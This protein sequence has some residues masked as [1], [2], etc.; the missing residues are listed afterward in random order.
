MEA[1]AY[2]LLNRLHKTIKRNGP[3]RKLYTAT[4]VDRPHSVESSYLGFHNR[5][6]WTPADWTF[7]IAEAGADMEDVVQLLKVTNDE[8]KTARD[9]MQKM[10]NQIVAMH[11]KTVGPLM[12]HIDDIRRKRQTLD[13]ETHQMLKALG[14]VREFFIESKYEIEIT[15]LKDFI[16]CL[17]KLQR[18]K[19]DGTLDAFADTIIH[20]A[21]KEKSNGGQQ[22]DEKGPQNQ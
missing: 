17:E 14:E 22:G 16:V 2:H 5:N 13:N 3:L 15:R 8:L 1:D 21:V 4:Y 9:E 7:P 10:C 6:G 20:L 18:F 11:H 12:D 19:Q